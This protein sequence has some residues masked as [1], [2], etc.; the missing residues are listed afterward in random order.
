MPSGIK[1]EIN[2]IHLWVENPFRYNNDDNNNND[3]NNELLLFF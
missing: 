2:R 1:G 3:N